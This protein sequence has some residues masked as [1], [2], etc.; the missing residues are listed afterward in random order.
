MQLAGFHIKGPSA[1]ATGLANDNSIR[2]AVR[3]F[4]ITCYRKRAVLYIDKGIL[5]YAVH[6][7]I[8]SQ[9]SAVADQVRSPCYGSIESFRS[10]VVDRQDMVLFC[11]FHEEVLHFLQ[12]RWV[13]CRQVVCLTK[14]FIHVI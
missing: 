12:F 1:E 2:I 6:T 7:R 13:L 4:D 11:Y 14:V 10:A 3:Q 9:R 5:R 8:N